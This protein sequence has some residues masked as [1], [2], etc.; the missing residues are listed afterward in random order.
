[1]TNKPALEWF[2]Q[3]PEPYR[4]QA[5]ENSTRPYSKYQS[6]FDALRCNFNWAET[7]QKKFYWHDI[8]ERAKLGEFDSPRTQTER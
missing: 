2:E 3:L 6:L 7:P 1:M 5:I 4:T 8:Y